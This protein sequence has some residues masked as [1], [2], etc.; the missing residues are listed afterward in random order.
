MLHSGCARLQPQQRGA[1]VPF[2]CASLSTRVVCEFADDSHSNTRLTTGRGRSGTY[3]LGH[4]KEEIVPLA[5]TWLN[6]EG[7][8]RS[9]MSQTRKHKHCGA[10]LTRE[11]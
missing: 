6:R 3:R 11:S 10:P 4:E 9:E 2:S 1:R 7:L 8:T 5:T